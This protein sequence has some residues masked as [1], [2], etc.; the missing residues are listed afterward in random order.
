MIY[1]RGDSNQVESQSK[2]ENKTP[3][4][5]QKRFRTKP[6]PSMIGSKI[7]VKYLRQ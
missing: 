1:K 6:P 3:R 7:L 2:R 4:A 5:F